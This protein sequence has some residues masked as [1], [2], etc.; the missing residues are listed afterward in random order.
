MIYKSILD[1]IGNTPLLYLEK[2]SKNNNC[3]IYLK[4]EKFNLTGSIKDRAVK[5]MLLEAIKNKQI[6]KNTTLIEPTSGNTGISLACLCAALSIKCIIVM[7]N[8][9]NIER[10][11]LIKSY[12]AQIIFTPKEDKMQGCINKTIELL[13]TIPNSFTLSQ[14]DNYNN[15]LAHYQ[16]TIKEIKNDLHDIDAIFASYGTGGTIS[17][18]AKY[19]NDNHEKT[20]TI[21]VIPNKKN[22]K[23][24][25]VYSNQDPKNLL[26]EYIDDYVFVSD[27]EAIENVKYLESIGLLLGLSSG[28]ILSGA[29]NY[30]KE[31]QMKNIVIICPDGGERYLSNPLLADLNDINKNEIQNDCDYMYNRIK[32]D[33]YLFDDIWLKYQLDENQICQLKEMF[34]EDANFYLENDPAAIS[35]KEIITLYPGLFATFVYRLSHI[36]W[37]NQYFLLARTLNEYAH[38][39]TNI[40]IHP[41]ATIGH[42]F[43]IDHGNGVVIGQTC[44]IGNN[45]RIYQN[46]TLGALSLNNP[47]KLKGCKRHPTIEDNVIIYAN[48]TILGGQTIIGKNTIIGSNVLVTSSIQPNVI[49]SLNNKN[50]QIKDKK[51]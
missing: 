9:S 17:G 13:K 12:N 40:D 42:K 38:S 10:I 4:L 50:Y 37:E 6:D 41:Q 26:K 22:H 1:L 48:A 43:C 36:F 49:V 34:F 35:I 30:L 39:K 46:V 51:K 5:N 19:L 24:I 18:I 2:L 28:L 16:T 25:G 11:K 47:L 3:N 29:L 44:K 33:D 15:I 31:H 32:D 8:N 45:V 14:F 23:I 7:P 27:K 20:K 21:C